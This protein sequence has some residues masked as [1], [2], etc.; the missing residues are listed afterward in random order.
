MKREEG[1]EEG[2]ECKKEE[3]GTE[4]RGVLKR[5]IGG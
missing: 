3:G 1:R 5:G 2:E 4:G